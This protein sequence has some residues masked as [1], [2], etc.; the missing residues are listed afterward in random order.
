[1]ERGCVG[2]E[3]ATQASHKHDQVHEF[4]RVIGLMI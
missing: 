2:C 4:E 3:Q 1:M